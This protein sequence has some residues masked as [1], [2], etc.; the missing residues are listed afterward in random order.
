M[1]LFKINQTKKPL[2]NFRTIQ[3]INMRFTNPINYIFTMLMLTFTFGY[4]QKDDD[5]GTEVVNVVKPY[6]AAVSDAF[7]IKETPVAKDEENTKKES[8]EYSIFSVPVASTFTPAKGKA[9]ALDQ[10]AADKFYNNYATLGFGNYGTLVG[11]LFLTKNFNQ[12]S[13]IGGMI[14]HHSSQGGI[15]EVVLDDNFSNT[16]VDVTYGSANKSL[17]WNADVGYQTQ[18]YNWYGMPTFLYENFSPE[19]QATF[20]SAV[21][22]KQTY[23]NLYLGG[24]FALENANFKGGEVKFNRFWD[25]YESG[26]NNLVLK[27]EF[28]FDVLNTTIKTRILVDHL[29]GSFAQNPFNTAE[30]LDYSLT[31]LGFAPSIALQ[32]NGWDFNLGAQLIYASDSENSE[33]KFFIYPEITASYG[34]VGDFMILY[35]GIEGTLRQNTYRNFATENPFVSPN[36]L[37]SPTDQQYDFFAGLKGKLASNISY[38]VRGSYMSEKNRAFFLNNGP[39]IFT[40]EPNNYD[41][42]NSFNVLYDDLKTITFF[43]ELKADI[44]KNFTAGINASVMS[45]TVSNTEEAWNL[46]SMQVGATSS[47]K[48]NEKWDIGAQFFYVGQRKDLTYEYGLNAIFPPDVVPSVATVAGYFDLNAQVFY[49]FNKRISA[50]VKAN[51]IANQAYERWVNYPSQQFQI[52]AGANFKFDF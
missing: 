24:R 5:L 39:N 45:Y 46:P 15:E 41:F 42:G 37:I 13:Y 20:I 10:E 35:G 31:N 7:K 16:Q 19:D 14:R 21:D 8:I 51:N 48:I 26:E 4:A 43:G 2:I 25:G 34:L 30:S 27:P 29:S 32:Q 11:E 49:S 18:T 52:M 50:F 9:A 12:N 23:A 38:N 17:A 44:S 22:S 36:L 1:L 33:S 6:T 3:Y 47:Y 40:S 28:A